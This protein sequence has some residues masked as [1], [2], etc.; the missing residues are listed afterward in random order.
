MKKLMDNFKFCKIYL[1]NYGL[2]YKYLKIIFVIKTITLLKHLDY[3]LRKYLK[4]KFVSA[5]KKSYTRF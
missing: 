4:D 3:Y 2:D 1:D 5:K